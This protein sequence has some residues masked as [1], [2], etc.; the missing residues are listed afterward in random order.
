MQTLATLGHFSLLQVRVIYVYVIPQYLEIRHY[1]QDWNKNLFWWN[2]HKHLEYWRIG[3]WAI[4]SLSLATSRAD[5]IIAI[6]IF[7]K[8]QQHKSFLAWDCVVVV[9][10]VVVDVGV[11]VTPAAAL[12]SSRCTKKDSSYFSRGKCFFRGVVIF[13]KR[14]TSVII[15]LCFWIEK[16]EEENI[17]NSWP[18]VWPRSLTCSESAT[19]SRS[20]VLESLDAELQLK[21]NKPGWTE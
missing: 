20:R 15:H 3:L 21:S 14:I 18:Q 16:Y 7:K 11:V 4:Y 10:V 8:L 12:A 1:N 5:A 9:I 17:M 6:Q 2:G 19:L 13:S